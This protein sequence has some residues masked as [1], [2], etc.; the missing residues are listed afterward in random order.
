VGL[1]VKLKR[2]KVIARASFIFWK[3]NFMGVM[4]SVWW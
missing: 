1:I 3:E 2:D 4:I